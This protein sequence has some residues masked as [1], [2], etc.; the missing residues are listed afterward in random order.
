[1]AA[2]GKRG[3]EKE[4]RK[5]DEDSREISRRPRREIPEWRQKV[6][7]TWRKRVG[8]RTERVRRLAKDQG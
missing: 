3:M 7:E 1:M 8:S 6:K 4:G 5:Q 2:E